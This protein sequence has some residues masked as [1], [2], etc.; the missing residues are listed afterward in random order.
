MKRI[1]D[2]K[3]IE[4]IIRLYKTDVKSTHKLSEMFGV[5]HKKISQVLKENNVEINKKGGQE[6]IGNSDIIEKSKINRYVTDTIG[7]KLIVVCKKTNKIFDDV[8]N[9]SGCL[10]RHI[11]ETYGDVDIPVTN[12]QR[13]KYEHINNKKWFE[14]YFDIREI[15]KKDY[16]KCCLCDWETTDIENKTGCFE[17]HINSVHKITLN[18]YL[19]KFPQDIKYHKTYLKEKERITEFLDEKNYVRCKLC[20]QKMKTITN[21]HLMEKHNISCYDY[22]IKFPNEILS[23]KLTRSKMSHNT[24]MSNI[25]MSPTWSS[26][27]EIE[28]REFIESLGFKTEK[29]KNRKILNGKEIDI[30]IPEFKIGIEYNGLYFHTEKMGKNSS[31]HLNKTIECNKIGYKLIQIFE[32]E[33][34]VKKDLVKSKIRHI[35]K[36]NNGIKIGGRNVIIKR[37]DS[38]LKSN[39]LNINHIQGNDN[40]KIHYGGFYKNELIGVM[41]FNDKRNMTKNKDEQYELSRYSIKEGY[42]VNGLA[43]KFIKTFKNEYSPKNIISFADRRW[44][45]DPENNLYIKMGFKL[46]GIN[47][48]T[49]TYYNSKKNKYKRF[50]KFG[51]GKNSLKLKHPDLDFTKSE[52]TLMNEL[53]YERIWDCGMFKYELFFD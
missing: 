37:I 14:E 39:F 32:D 40:S 27:G 45:L 51:F 23:S 3:D 7:H 4:N 16:R 10:T 18:E 41:T 1:L 15:L 53:G 19:E 50:H 47:K 38:L 46:V 49:Y 24:K 21:K 8:N 48:P 31:Y 9:V 42:V 17:T 52:K 2:N 25:N 29:G 36:I 35:L 6:K 34:V 30:I 26:S 33:W 5:G 44:T 12:Y 43:S 28:L 11:V 22:K 20:D 13:K